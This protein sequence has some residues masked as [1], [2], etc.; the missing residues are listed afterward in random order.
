MP[1]EM[2]VIRTGALLDVERGE[3]LADQAI[4]VRDGRV[5]AV[6]P[7]NAPPSPMVRPRSTCRA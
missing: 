2:V 3:L 5:E 1:D 4:V 6:L 7:A